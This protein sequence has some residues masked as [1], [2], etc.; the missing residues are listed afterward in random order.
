MSNNRDGIMDWRT[1]SDGP[2]NEDA[3]RKYLDGGFHGLRYRSSA[4]MRDLS[5]LESLP[6]LRYLSIDAKV[7]DDR[8][9]FR[10]ETLEELVLI[11]GS[12]RAGPESLQPNLKSLLVMDRPG[13]SVSTN[14]PQLE[15]IRIGSW[16]GRDLRIFEGADS[17]KHVRLEGSRQQGSLIGIDSCRNLIEFESVNYSVVDTTP[18]VNSNSLASVSLM[19]A[20]PTP[21]HEEVDFEDFAS[22][23]VERIWIS[24]AMRLN[25][26]RSLG[27][28]VRLRNLRLVECNVDASMLQILQSLPTA[29]NVEV[30]D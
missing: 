11:T 1:R 17:L 28:S 2:W 9:A 19:A 4:K 16:K 24:N 18:F 7:L 23:P 29:I 14:W 15:R 30:L 13:L 3:R 10:L 26:V 27:S 21:P 8:Q 22:A 20:S 6:G 5:F 25:G 12:R